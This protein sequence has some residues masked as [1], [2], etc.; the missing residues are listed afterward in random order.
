MLGGWLALGVLV[1]FLGPLLTLGERQP[2][3]GDTGRALALAALALAAAGHASWRALRLARQNRALVDGLAGDPAARA[4]APAGSEVALLGAR[5]DAALKVL[6]RGT[7]GPRRGLFGRRR[8]LYE[9]PWFV[10]IGAP[11]AGKTTALLNSGLQF[12]LA[13]Q[14]GGKVVRGI[15]GTRHCDWWFTDRAVLID[16]AGRYTTQ[17]SDRSVDRAGWLG[18]LDLLAR[19]RAQRPIDGVLLTLAADELLAQDAAAHAA[20][21]HELRARL[22]ELHERL[23]VRP[24]VYVLVT[25]TDL[26]AGFA[27]FFADY[28]RDERAQVW[29]VSFPWAAGAADAERAEGDPL[30]RLPSD[31]A[32]LEKRLDDQLFERLRAETDRER[33]AALYAFPR[34]WRQ[35]R[36]AV[37]DVV[38]TAFVPT[39]DGRRPMLRG[40][41]FTSATQEG[42]PMDRALGGV[43]RAM[44]L[45][46][47][48][49][50]PARATGK[51][52][53]VTELIRDV[54]LGEVGIA[55]R[56]ARQARWQ[57]H[58]VMTGAAASILG[59]G[60]IAV[61]AWRA[62]QDQ[63]TWLAQWQQRDAVLGPASDAAARSQPTDLLGLLP[64]LDLLAPDGPG[65]V[66]GSADAVPRTEP[67][68]AAGRPGPADA[69][70]R[71]LALGLDR[72][73][74]VDAARAD[75]Y[76]KLLRDALLP[77]IAAR[78][79]ARLRQPAGPDDLALTQE[80]LKAYLMLFDGQH[81]NHRDLRAYLDAE[82][83]QGLPAGTTAAQRQALLR[84]LD[85][86][87]ALGEAGAPARADA[88]LIA[89]VRARVAEVPLEQRLYS[90]LRTMDRGRS[91][92][93]PSVLSLAGPEAATVFVR[94]SG[95]PLA[96][97]IA[98]LYTRAVA[99]DGALPAQIDAALSALQAEEPWV[100]GTAATPVTSRAPL[101][102][103]IE[104]RY[105]DELQQHWTAFADDL[106]IVTA[107]QLAGNAERVQTLARTDGPLAL[108]A[109][110]LARELPVEAEP[111]TAWTAANGGLDPLLARLGK[112]ATQLA[113]AQDAIAR[114]AEAPPFDAL[115]EVGDSI[116]RAPAPLQPALHGLL[117]PIAA[118]LWS[119]LHDSL[120]RELTS[121]VT[122]ACQ[123]AVEGRYPFSRDA[124]AD[125]DPAALQAAFGPNGAFDRW[126][127]SRLAP[128]VDT[129]ARPWRWRAGLPGAGSA[130]PLLQSFQRA[131]QW[132]DGLFAAGGVP[133]MQLE[134]RL[135]E[136]DP[137]LGQFTV[138]VDGQALR[139]TRDNARSPQWLRWPGAQGGRRLQVQAGSGAAYGFDGPW[140]PW[141]LL[142]RVRTEPAGS[143]D[144]VRLVFDVEGRRARFEARSTSGPLPFPLTELEAFA[145]PRRW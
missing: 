127:R 64:V 36:D 123:R 77:R 140:A 17:D 40:L 55:G 122:P 14:V 33:S 119:G 111:W 44:G 63:R 128:F 143:A 68:G 93:A 125:A 43:A 8:T 135:I 60:V 112:L 51:T 79:E 137:A 110:G 101:V 10:M 81:V 52:Y 72:H 56:S 34:Q 98:P 116:G 11:G 82:W 6:R 129:G 18:F 41:Y 70:A 7:L 96:E 94:A 134:L 30:A 58:A 61:L 45:S 120:E 74:T 133:A 39:G 138:D 145:C 54:V 90:R 136:L 113:A 35:L 73:D 141:R 84:H 132:R 29:G 115:A 16:T 71:W 25:K 42:T 121:Q 5:F 37:A 139:F 67:G 76:G 62:S 88:A 126:T 26:V 21:A 91:L 106:R 100:L 59:L 83:Q 50:T 87:L 9:L 32:G 78:L 69:A 46:H 144:R 13:E 105:R 22:D 124:G 31:L 109:R 107:P 89:Q 24:P 2:L 130:S 28:D 4:S 15:G 48:V 108:W 92:Q 66:A 38:T 19:H 57:R 65:A 86:L 47:R 20:H 102:A 95:S 103:A 104:R 53:F 75:A 23:G 27:E 114:R 97:R 1:W 131:Q 118:Q 12:P 80:A 142:E 3:A 117:E 85:A 99:A 49:V